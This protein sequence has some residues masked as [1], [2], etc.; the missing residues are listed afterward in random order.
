MAANCAA[1]LARNM[2]PSRLFVAACETKR[3]TLVSTPS[4][5]PDVRPAETFKVAA[6]PAEHVKAD[7]WA[8]LRLAFYERGV[9][10]VLRERGWLTLLA[11]SRRIDRF[12]SACGEGHVDVT[13]HELRAFEIRMGQSGAEVPGIVSVMSSNLASK[14]I[15]LLNLSTYDSDLI[16]VRTDQVEEARVTFREQF[17]GEASRGGGDAAASAEPA[18]PGPEDVVGTPRGRV[19]INVLDAG[20]RVVRIRKEALTSCLPTLT[21]LLLYEDYVWRPSDA[22]DAGGEAAKSPRREQAAEDFRAP[23]HAASDGGWIAGAMA[24]GAA[25]TGAAEVAAAGASGAVCT[26]GNV[27]WAYLS[28]P[29]EISL[30][31]D[32]AGLA[33]FPREAVI[34]DPMTFRALQ[35]QSDET[36]DFDSIGCV[37]AMSSPLAEISVSILNISSYHTNY[38]LVPDGDEEKSAAA[39]RAS[40]GA[41]E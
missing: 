16:C 20:F 29:G 17:A 4:I 21:Q 39:L 1:L 37:S 19:E 35:L 30:I 7:A 36:F 28:L 2:R 10:S 32:A 27:F 31:I 15:S 8:L 13:A 6:L 14:G 12:A 33:L 5:C 25:G 38:S 3:L 40:L 41:G 9:V 18:A 11:E 34:D 22:S 24:A 26:A 23:L